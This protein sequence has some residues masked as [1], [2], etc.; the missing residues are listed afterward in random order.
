MK[1]R[2]P[3]LASSLALALALALATAGCGGEAVHPAADPEPV[4]AR[5]A[6]AVR[7]ELPL[8]VEV[9]GTVTAERV[10]AVAARISAAVTAVHVQA[11]DRVAAGRLLLEIDPEP[12]AGHTAQARGALLQAEA[13]LALARRNHERYR[14]L[15]EADAASELEVDLARTQ[16][17]QAEGAVEQAEGALAAAGALAADA[18][19]VAPFAGRVTRRMVEVGDLA[20]P[21]RPLL[22]IESEGG[23]RLAL[24][25]PESVV[26]AAGLD[27]GD[28]VAVAIDSRPGLGVLSAEVVEMA[29]GPDPTSHAVDVEVALPVEGLPAGAAGRAWIVTGRRSAVVV[30]A[31]AVLRHGGLDLVVVRGDDGRASTRAVTVT[32]IRTAVHGA[33]PGE[34]VEVLSGLDGGETVAVGLGALPPAGARLEEALLKEARLEEVQ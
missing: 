5:L 7:A 33:A 26:A 14:A 20:A 30:P 27:P 9:S 12:A 24:A 3:L 10:A 15:A 28:A 19:V 13:A 18:R 2:N 23:R 16:L 11:G 25:V 34:T 1:I 8:T 31:A 29:P 17:E 21:G 4:R 6:E 22:T 32:A